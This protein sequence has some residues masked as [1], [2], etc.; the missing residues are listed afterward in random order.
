MIDKLM[1]LLAFAVLLGFL[2]ILVFYVPR[3][4]LG[5][6]VAATLL[7]AVYDLFFFDRRNKQP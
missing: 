1:A 5:F 7:F 4:D 6:V 3:W 2:G